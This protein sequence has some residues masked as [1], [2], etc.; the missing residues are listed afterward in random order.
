MFS[1]NSSNGLFLFSPTDL[2]CSKF[3]PPCLRCQSL[4]NLALYQ[5]Y[6]VAN[7]SWSP[8]LV[9]ERS[10]SILN[11]SLTL[12]PNLVNPQLT[13]PSGLEISIFLNILMVLSSCILPLFSPIGCNHVKP[14]LELLPAC[15]WSVIA[16]YT[17]LVPPQ[18]KSQ[19]KLHKKIQRIFQILKINLS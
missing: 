2:V 12:P 16:L 19:C 13:L 15:S 11:F 4:F 3:S 5:S 8:P 9:L 1:V 14:L 18:L 6:P 10:L 7:P 17:P